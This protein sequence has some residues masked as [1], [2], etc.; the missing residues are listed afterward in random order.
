MYRVAEI[1][2][3]FFFMYETRLMEKHTT[4]VVQTLDDR[5]ETLEISDNCCDQMLQQRDNRHPGWPCL[6]HVREDFGL[7]RVFIS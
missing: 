5:I 7:C 1:S 2:D 3:A 4:V 6:V